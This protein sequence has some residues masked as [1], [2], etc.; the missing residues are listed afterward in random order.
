[1][2]RVTRAMR[3]GSQ[4]VTNDD[5]GEGHDTPQKWWR[6]LWTGPQPNLPK[7][8]T[9]IYP[10]HFATLHDLVWVNPCPGGGSTLDPPFRSLLC[11]GVRPPWAPMLPIRASANI[12]LATS[13]P[14]RGT[15]GGRWDRETSLAL[16]CG[17]CSAADGWGELGRYFGFRLGKH[18]PELQNTHLWSAMIGEVRQ[19][20][21]QMVRLGYN[22]L[23]SNKIFS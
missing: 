23:S 16:L 7:K 21:L 2:S 3:G 15:A 13:P 17:V 12:S 6:H 4:K 18:F 5:E 19:R 9:L 11:S 22:V 10:S 20:F 14:G 8:I 1:M